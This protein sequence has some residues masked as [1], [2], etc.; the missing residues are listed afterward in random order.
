M[1]TFKPKFNFR[2]HIYVKLSH[3]FTR[4]NK[5]ARHNVPQCTVFMVETC[6]SVTVHAAK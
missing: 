1:E 3:W 6:P 2:Q 5:G 4:P